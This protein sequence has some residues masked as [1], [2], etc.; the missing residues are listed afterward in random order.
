MGRSRCRRRASRVG[1]GRDERD[2]EITYR[3]SAT[4]DLVE[5]TGSN[6]EEGIIIDGVRS[7]HLGTHVHLPLQTETW[8]WCR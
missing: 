2:P 4:T 8:S 5:S 3:R 1:I 6:G 7:N